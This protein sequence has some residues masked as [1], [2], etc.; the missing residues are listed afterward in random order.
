MD[1]VV[2]TSTAEDRQRF[3]IMV[4]RLQKHDLAIARAVG[5]CQLGCP[6]FTAEMM[7]VRSPATYAQVA[8][9]VIFC[10]LNYPGNE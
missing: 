5:Q 3:V 4:D 2:D 7:D 8:A 6:A 10:R 9:K 1:A